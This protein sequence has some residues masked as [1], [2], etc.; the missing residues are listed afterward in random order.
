MNNHNGVML[1]KGT[2]ICEPK[3]TLFFCCDFF[4]PFC[5]KFEEKKKEIRKKSNKKKQNDSQGCQNAELSTA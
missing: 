5:S 1:E 4:F 3:L 2:P